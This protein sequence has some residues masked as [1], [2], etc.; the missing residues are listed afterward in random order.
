MNLLVSVGSTRFDSLIEEICSSSFLRMLED[1]GFTSITI[2][3]GK[4][5]ILIEESTKILKI[6]TFSYIDHITFISFMD[7]SQFIIA[8]CGSGIILDY[9]KSKDKKIYNQ[10]KLFLVPN[11]LLMD[12]HQVELGKEISTFVGNCYL[13]ETGESINELL[14]RGLIDERKD[15]NINKLPIAPIGSLKRRINLLLN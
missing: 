1:E 6:Q 7:S 2:Q 3:H 12:D 10:K 8:H 15:I 4:S 9:L 14:Q 11:H 13:L 5:P